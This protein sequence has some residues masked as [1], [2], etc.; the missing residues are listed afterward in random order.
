MVEVAQLG[1]VDGLGIEKKRYYMQV[2]TSTSAL[3]HTRSSRRR[4]TVMRLMRSCD[5]ANCVGVGYGR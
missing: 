5:A 1:S 2:H 4:K 3:G